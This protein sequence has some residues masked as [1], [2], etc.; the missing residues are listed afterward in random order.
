MSRLFDLQKIRTQDI[1][2]KYRT[3]LNCKKKDEIAI[4]ADKFFL[5]S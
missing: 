4:F 2:T 5:I 1:L 3:V